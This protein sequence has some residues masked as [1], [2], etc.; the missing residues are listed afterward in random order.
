MMPAIDAKGCG[1][2]YANGTITSTMWLMI[3]PAAWTPF[4]IQ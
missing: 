1:A 2:K 4:G 3:T